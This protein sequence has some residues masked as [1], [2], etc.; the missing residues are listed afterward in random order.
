MR[1]GFLGFSIVVLTGITAAVVSAQTTGNPPPPLPRSTPPPAIQG[2]GQ[3]PSTSTIIENAFARL[4][5]GA[6]REQREKGYAKLLEGQRHVENAKRSGRNEYEQNIRLAKQ[7]FLSALEA[8]PS[9]SEAY[10]AVAELSTIDEAIKI[11][12]F[13]VKINPNSYSGH[14]ML[15]RVYTIKARLTEA[16][17]DKSFVEK[18]IAEWKEVSRLDPRGAEPWAYLSELYNRMDRPAEELEALNKWIGSVA[19]ASRMDFEFYRR[20]SGGGDLSPENASIRLARAFLK[21]G[22]DKEALEVISRKIADEPDNEEAVELLKQAMEKSGKD[23]AAQVIQA[24]EQAVYANPANVTLVEVLAATQSRMGMTDAA[25][26]TIQNSISKLD[27]SE[28]LTVARLQLALGDTYAEAEK[29]SDAIAAYEDALKTQGIAA[30]TSLNEADRFFASQ[31]ISGIIQLHKNNQQYDEAKAV[32]ER[33]RE[34]FGKEDPFADLQLLKLLRDSGKKAEALKAVKALRVKAPTSDEYFYQ[35]AMI[36]TEMG[37]VEEAVAMIRTKIVN[38]GKILTNQAAATRDINNYLMI[39]Q[40]Y[41]QAK[42]GPKAVD[43]AQTALML[44]QGDDLKQIVLLSLAT[45]QNEAGDF[46]ASEKTLRDIIEK[47]PDNF[48]ALNNLGYFLADRGEK[49]E[50]A[51]QMI[52][53]AVKAQPENS[54]FLD[55]LGWAHFK[56]GNL[57]EA[58]KYLR[59]SLRHDAAASATLDHLGDVY[60]KQGKL[61]LA[62]V[63]WQKALNLTTDNAEVAKIKAKLSKKTTSKN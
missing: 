61:E 10:V 8:D 16:N 17:F 19:P 30:G 52:Q 62:R 15:G 57:D 36:L 43:A 48:T 11:V 22:R 49:L 6:T 59:E 31:V 27:K 60:A 55:S 39:S 1:K 53:K 21:A 18:A 56:L 50:E 37:R 29:P 2:P 5:D 7:S 32:I 47:T 28:K 45:A 63:H 51:L 14:R 54:S 23:S 33:T 34:M 12:G 58:E 35:E 38:K 9:I 25:I 26:K 40:L 13:A 46:K 41:T 24:L 44:A 4:K 3:G 42:Q 20:A